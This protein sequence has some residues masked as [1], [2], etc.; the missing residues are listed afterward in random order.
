MYVDI[1]IS[2]SNIAGRYSSPPTTLH[3]KFKPA[4]SSLK[5]SACT[6]VAAVSPS[7]FTLVIP[8]IGSAPLAV[9]LR[10]NNTCVLSNKPFE[11]RKLSKYPFCINTK[12]GKRFLGQESTIPSS[13]SLRV[14]TKMGPVPSV[15]MLSP[16]PRSRVLSPPPFARREPIRPP[17]ITV[18]DDEVLLPL[19]LLLE[20]PSV[21]PRFSSQAFFRAHFCAP[22]DAIIVKLVDVVLQLWTRKGFVV[23][24][25][26]ERGVVIFMVGGWEGCRWRGLLM[27]GGRGDC[28]IYIGK[29]YFDVW[30][31][32]RSHKNSYQLTSLHRSH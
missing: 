16:R 1:H 18:Q 13:E 22:R 15:G 8:S 21:K 17:P 31:S 2:F 24:K 25:R 10:Y 5:A 20:R 4:K 29:T 14:A 28:D 26:T 6:P 32:V 11:E 30:P 3:F 7:G 27:I 19:L 23:K 9:T 12:S